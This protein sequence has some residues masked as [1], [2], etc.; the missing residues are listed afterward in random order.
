MQTA[1]TGCLLA[2]VIIV[3]MVME[4]GSATVAGCLA[5]GHKVDNQPHSA[6]A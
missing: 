1:E 6:L 3:V 4:L 5:V 2:V